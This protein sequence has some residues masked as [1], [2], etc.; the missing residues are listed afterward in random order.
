LEEHEIAFLVGWN[1]TERMKLSMRGFLHL[2]ERQESNVIRLA[3]FFERPADAHIARESPTTVGRPFKSG[4][5]RGRWLS[6]LRFSC[7]RSLQPK[8][9]ARIRTPTSYGNCA[10]GQPGCRSWPEGAM[11]RFL[12]AIGYLALCVLTT[13]TGGIAGAWWPVRDTSEPSAGDGLG[14]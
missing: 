11:A 5:G 2:T 8:D 10:A 6:H 3:H 9:E 12:R 1:L 4:E 13:L 7:F 14:M